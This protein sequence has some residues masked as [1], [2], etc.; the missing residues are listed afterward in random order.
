[1][2]PVLYSTAT[3]TAN[4]PGAL[5]VLRYPIVSLHQTEIIDYAAK[6]RLPAIHARTKN[7]SSNHPIR[8]RQHVRRNREADLLGRFEI[9]DQLEFRRLFDGKI[10]W[11]CTF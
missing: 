4:G 11:L 7:L 10:G 2:G 6:R 9:D 3:I 8:P 1:M 5:F